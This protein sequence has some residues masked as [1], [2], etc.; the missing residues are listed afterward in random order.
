MQQLAS[1]F[2]NFRGVFRIAK[3]IDVGTHMSLIRRGNGR[4]LLI[5]SYAVT[6]ADR[7]SLLQ[8]TDGGG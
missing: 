5:D 2:W 3:L 1:N 8:L 4:F 6:G 7:D